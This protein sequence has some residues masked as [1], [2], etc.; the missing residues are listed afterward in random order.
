MSDYYFKQINPEH[1]C[2]AYL[3][4]PVNSKS[5]AIVDPELEHIDEYLDL[6]RKENFTLKYIID[7]HTHAD[8][9]SGAAA[10]KEESDAKLI[11]HKKAPAKCVSIRVSNGD[12]LDFEGLNIKFIET[13][14]HTKDSI[15]I[16]L[17]GKILTGDSLF[18]DDGGAG[19]DDL[20]GGSSELH[21]E[22]FQKFLSLPEDLIVFPAH[23]YRDRKPSSLKKQKESNPF[24]KPRTKEEYVEFLLDLQLGPA[25][26]MKDVLKANYE[27]TTDPKAAW[28]P[29]DS[30]SCEVMGTLQP[31]VEEQQVNNILPRKLQEKLDNKE[32]FVFIDVRGISELHGKLGKVVEAINIPL[33]SIMNDV[34]QMNKYIN[35]SIVAICGGGKRSIIAAKMLKK[36]GFKNPLYVEGGI[37]AWRKIK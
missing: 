4:G 5:V 37:R 6:L 25:E 13:P 19:R 14:G 16:I 34:G 2:K 7:T 17:P 29:I 33:T 3:F 15:S 18:L 24:L 20:P 1:T 22:T 31:G 32:D 30:P 26:W 8:H 23:D 9:L 35:K 12:E 21:W 28:V 36:S 10:L 11:M 27:C